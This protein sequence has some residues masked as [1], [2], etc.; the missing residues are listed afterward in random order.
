VRD[1]VGDHSVPLPPTGG[2]YTMGGRGPVRRLDVPQLVGRGRQSGSTEQPEGQAP[3]PGP[4]A[5]ADA[6]HSKVQ[7]LGSSPPVRM[8]FAS[9]WQAI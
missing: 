4:D 9:L 8:V 7:A 5:R 2:L 3:P 1:R 6:A